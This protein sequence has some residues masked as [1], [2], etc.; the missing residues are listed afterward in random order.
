[1]SSSYYILCLSHDPATTVRECST[2]ETAAAAI[3]AGIEAHTGCDLLIERVSGGP[4]EYGCPPH[5]TR[6]AG[7][8]CYHRDVGWVDTQ[9]L[10]L[11]GHAR[12]SPDPGMQKAIK[13]GYF[14]CWTRDRLHRLRHSLGTAEE[15]EIR[16]WA[17]DG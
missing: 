16:P 13:Q 7:P 4:V 5:D 15:L 14:R 3:K 1:V 11:L 2:A 8:H 9:W 6:R 12:I 17:C 10:Q